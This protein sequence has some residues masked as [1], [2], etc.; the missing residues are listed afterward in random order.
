MHVLKWAFQC[1]NSMH[2]YMGEQGEDDEREVENARMEADDIVGYDVAVL[3]SDAFDVGDNGVASL[4]KEEE[5]GGVVSEVTAARGEGE[6][7]RTS[8]TSII[9]WTRHHLGQGRPKRTSR[10]T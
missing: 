4:R 10:P 6:K 7:V 9:G 8:A 1:V 3:P 2:V 5:S